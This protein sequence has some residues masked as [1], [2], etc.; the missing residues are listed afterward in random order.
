MRRMIILFGIITGQRDGS[1][2]P[3]EIRMIFGKNIEC[4]GNYPSKNPLMT[5]ERLFFT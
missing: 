2:V 5:L 3:G 1:L 4:W